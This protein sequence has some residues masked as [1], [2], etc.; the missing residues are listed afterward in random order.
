GT[1]QQRSRKSFRTEGDGMNRNTTTRGFFQLARL[2]RARAVQVLLMAAA[3][4]LLISRVN[5]QPFPQCPPVGADTSCGVLLTITPGGFSVV[6]SD[7]TQGPFDGVEDTLTGVQNNSGGPVCSI[8]LS[9]TTD[10]FGFD[11]DGICAG[12]SPGPAGC[13][14]G[15]TGYEGPG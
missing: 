12:Y 7:P 4:V 1:F 11:D 8:A 6:A 3:P 9:S 10:I 15:P 14:F 13:P 2:H 5:A